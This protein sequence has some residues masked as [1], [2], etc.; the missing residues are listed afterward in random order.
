MA[1]SS[2]LRTRK[3]KIRKEGRKGRGRGGV[4]T[5]G[6]QRCRGNHAEDPRR[7][8]LRLRFFVRDLQHTFA[9]LIGESGFR[10]FERVLG[11]WHLP[12][13]RRRQLLD[14]PHVHRPPS[15]LF[16]QI[17]KKSDPK[18]RIDR[19]AFIGS[20]LPRLFPSFLGGFEKYDESNDGR[21][22]FSLFVSFASRGR[23]CQS[24]NDVCM[25]NVASKRLS[26]ETTVSRFRTVYLR[27]LCLSFPLAVFFLTP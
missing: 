18:V 1:S 20:F 17:R 21:L 8:N 2:N 26:N 24:S 15:P 23:I 11:R 5:Y 7:C 10:D 9:S 25:Y 27:E 13:H 6:P 16:L 12:R 22:F 3:G 14:P 19:V 4:L